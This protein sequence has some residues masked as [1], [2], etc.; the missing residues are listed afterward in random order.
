MTLLLR[1]L[2][3]LA[4]LAGAD[5][6]ASGALAVRAPVA[7]RSSV[8]MGAVASVKFDGA[9]A[10]EVPVELKI[11]KSG[12]YLVHRKVV[13]EQ[14][15]MRLGTAKAKTRMEASSCPRCSSVSQASAA[16]PRTDS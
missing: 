10:G 14:A 13:A 12:A 1:A 8:M 4:L 6:L 15:N 3:A 9:A 7:A 16:V 2:A 5:A 11:A